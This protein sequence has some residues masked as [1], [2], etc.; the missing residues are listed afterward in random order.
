MF[1]E[2]PSQLSAN[3]G[4]VAGEVTCHRSFCEVLVVTECDGTR[5][6]DT[7]PLSLLVSAPGKV[8][9][10]GEQRLCTGKVVLP[11]CFIWAVCLT[12][13]WVLEAYGLGGLCGRAC[14]SVEGVPA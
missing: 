12:Q 5:S 9:C 1:G 8:F 6:I 7:D 4:L 10:H 13:A 2:F 14:A 3:G 11:E